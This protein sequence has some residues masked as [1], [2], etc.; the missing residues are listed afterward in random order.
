MSAAFERFLGLVLRDDVVTDPRQR[1]YLLATVK[2]ETGGLWVPVY[3]K[4]NG[5]PVEYFTKKYEGREDLGN[6]EPGDGY[7]YRGRGPVQITGRGQ[8]DRVGKRINVD[9]V[10][11]PDLAMKE[12]VGY[13]IASIGMAEGLF[14]QG[15]RSL[16]R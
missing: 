14:T 5:D 6:T 1:A 15:G 3:E 12:G 7:L 10:N 13:L 8:Y 9:L 16:G 2:H 11:N 4:Y